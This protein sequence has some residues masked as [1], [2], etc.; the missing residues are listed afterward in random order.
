MGVK[1]GLRTRLINA[2]ADSVKAIHLPKLKIASRLNGN[3]DYIHLFAKSQAELHRN[4]VKLKSHLKPD[5]M[6]WISWPKGKKL[7]TDLSITKVIEIG[8]DYGLQSVKYRCH[9]V[10]IE[11]YSS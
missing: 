2:P 11:I 4:F 3:F 5:G 6:L 9:L 7:E 10:S 8:Y 1:E